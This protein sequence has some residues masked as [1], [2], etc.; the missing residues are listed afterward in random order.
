MKKILRSFLA[1]VL[2]VIF[3][4]SFI[5]SSLALPNDDIVTIATRE[6]GNTKGTKY[7][8]SAWCA[9]FVVWCAKQSGIA[10]NVIPYTGGCT[11]MYNDLLSKCGAKIVTAP[12]KGDLV[13]YKSHVT[14]GYYAH[15]G[16]MIN[17][18]ASIQGNLTP[19][20]GAAA[21][22]M[23]LSSALY[24]VYSTGERAVLSD[25]VFVRPNY[26][27][28]VSSLKLNASSVTMKAGQRAFL[29]ETIYP[30]NASNKNVTWSSSNTN[31][32]YVN[33]MGVLYAQKKGTAIITVISS[34]GIKVTCKVT[35][36]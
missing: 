31:I 14:N 34:N 24:Y 35:V 9:H 10:S 29:T 20:K 32:V 7:G 22:V 1:F 16:I 12:Q 19:K 25:L 3:F 4:M 11:Q 33:F 6:I 13:F 2:S 30:A 15:V 21:Q 28:P 18:N 23:Q 8:N 36:K 26:T 17:G 5:S 27:V